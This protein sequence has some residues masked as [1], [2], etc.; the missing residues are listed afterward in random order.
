M[1]WQSVTKMMKQ[2]SLSVLGEFEQPSLVILS[3]HR[4]VDLS[5]LTILRPGYEF[6]SRS[7]SAFS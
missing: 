2:L 6:E 1:G 7:T 4:P 5:V 3:G